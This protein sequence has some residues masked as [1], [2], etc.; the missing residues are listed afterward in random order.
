MKKVLFATTALVASA[1][2]ASA[3]GVELS[4]SAEMGIV[5]G[6]GIETQFHTGVDV[7]FT[8]SGETDNGLTFGATV[9]LDDT[10]ETAV[11]GF[12]IADTGPSE[13]ADYN[14]FISGN[15]GTLTMGDTDGAFDWALRDLDII[16]DINDSN[17]AHAG[18]NGNAGLDGTYDGQVARYD[19]SFGDFA[20]A[21]SA[22]I[23][24]A[25]VGDPVFGIGGTYSGDLGGVN[26]GVGLGYQSDGVFDIIG[27]SLD[28]SF[29][30]G[31]RAI[32]NYSDLD[33]I[34]I[35]NSGY[36]GLPA[37][38]QFAENHIGVGLFYT[39]DALSVGVNYGVYDTTTIGCP[40]CADT[41]GF[42]LAVNY[43]LGGGAVVQFGYG[44]SSV[45]NTLVPG[46]TVTSDSFS[47]GVAMSF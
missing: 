4:G 37:G 14:V 27:V 2:I 34:G 8:M 5:G 39:M 9:D 35:D 10:G 43:D 20:F 36:G 1:G 31:I 29:D 42:G 45:Q 32:L 23:D 24:D 41:E 28:A 44:S 17:T 33:G 47:L 16:A 21:V 26:L 22:E 19:Y 46:D 18:F 7:R 6:D 15:F 13:L 11:R 3:Q 40:T 12:D 30:N 38:T 25:G